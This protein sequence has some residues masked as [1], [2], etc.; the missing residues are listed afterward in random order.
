MRA[1]IQRVSPEACPGRSRPVELEMLQDRIE[2][3]LV[4]IEAG[5][6]EVVFCI[7]G[8]DEVEHR[9]ASDALDGRGQSGNVL[10]EPLD[11]ATRRRASATSMNSLW[12]P[13]S[14]IAPR[15]T[16]ARSSNSRAGSPEARNSSSKCW[17]AAAG[18]PLTRP[19]R[20]TSGAGNAASES[21]MLSRDD[22]AGFQTKL[23]ASAV[24]VELAA[25]RHAAIPADQRG[26]ERHQAEPSPRRLHLLA[27]ELTRVGARTS[28]QLARPT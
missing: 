13:A 1:P 2:H 4:V 24:G 21:F 19:E 28:S 7:G 10:E 9:G 22:G 3:C 17:R 25:R 8:A 26:L 27:D 15:C 16:R 14:S 12:R 18:M 20:S 23:V 11:S 5:E 6:L